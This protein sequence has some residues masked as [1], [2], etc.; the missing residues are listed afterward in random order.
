MIRDGIYKMVGGCLLSIALLSTLSSCIKEGIE[1]CDTSYSLIV[2]AYDNE[3]KEVSDS[4]NMPVLLYL[5]DEQRLFLKEIETR[6]NTNVQ[7]EAPNKERVTVIAWGNLHGVRQSKPVLRYGDQMENYRVELNR[8]GDQ[9][10]IY[11]SPDAL[12]YGGIALDDQQFSGETTLPLYHATGGLTIRVIGVGE[13]IAIDEE[14]FSITVGKTYNAFGFDG[15]PAGDKVASY[16]PEGAFIDSE[17]KA[18]EYFVPIFRLVPDDEITIDLYHQNERIYN[19]NSY[20]DAPLSI[21]KGLVTNVLIV[22]ENS[23]IN[24]HIAL[25]PWGQYHVWKVFE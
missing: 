3:G 2:K 13:N 25:S 12:F 11:Q 5:F 24:V 6:T 8:V 20:H 4:D 21:L 15:H 22:I 10:T 19:I 16:Q 9:P 23:G 18:K 1:S 7:I 17:G 14:A